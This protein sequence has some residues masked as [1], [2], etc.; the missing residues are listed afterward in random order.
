MTTQPSVSK[1][2]VREAT[3]AGGWTSVNVMTGAGCS[4]L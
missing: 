2:A 3:M 1:G 4:I